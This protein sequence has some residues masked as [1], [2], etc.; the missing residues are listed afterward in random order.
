MS[1]DNISNLLKDSLPNVI[2]FWFNQ[3]SFYNNWFQSDYQKKKF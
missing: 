3:D 2:E 1:N